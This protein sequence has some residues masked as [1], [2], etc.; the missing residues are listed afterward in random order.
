M[1]LHIYNTVVLGKERELYRTKANALI[2][3][4]QPLGGVG[5]R[6]RPRLLGI[7]ISPPLTPKA[8][9]RVFSRTVIQY[10]PIH[11]FSRVVRIL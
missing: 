5:R 4:L 1:A 11:H 7:A 10:S 9:N 3:P 6:Y 8:F 2:L